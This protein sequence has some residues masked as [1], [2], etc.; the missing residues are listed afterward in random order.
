MKTITRSI[1]LL[2]TV[3]AVHLALA[4]CS[5]EGMAHADPDVAAWEPCSEGVARHAFPGV[6][7]AELAELHALAKTKIPDDDPRSFV[8]VQSPAT[9]YGGCAYVACGAGVEAVL[10]VLP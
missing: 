10:F 4:A 7:I 9:I 8:Y 1:A 2:T 6:T 5:P 3:S